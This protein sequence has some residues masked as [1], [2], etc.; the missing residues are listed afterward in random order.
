MMLHGCSVSR[1]SSSPKVTSGGSSSS[2]KAEGG[3]RTLQISGGALGDDAGSNAASVLF[4]FK[5]EAEAVAWERCLKEVIATLKEQQQQPTTPATG[6]AGTRGGAATG[7]GAAPAEVNGAEGS[8]GAQGK[9]SG[10]LAPET[11]DDRDQIRQLTEMG[12]LNHYKLTHMLESYIRIVQQSLCDLVPKAVTSHLLDE[13]LQAINSRLDPTLGRGSMATA[14]AELMAPSAEQAAKLQRLK[15]EVACLREARDIVAHVRTPP[16]AQSAA[17]ARQPAPPPA[18]ALERASK[19][20]LAAPRAPLSVATNQ[21]SSTP[22]STRRGSARTADGV[23]RE[24]L[25]STRT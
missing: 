21:A 20:A 14:V 11:E 6:A 10:V 17:A 7:A 15:A 2:S 1:A 23:G 25:L 4:E 22:P 19:E 8:L 13:T 18:L 24:H 9:S 3:C 5:E 16:P 12:R